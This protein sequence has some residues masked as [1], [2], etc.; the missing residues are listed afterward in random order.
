MIKNKEVIKL[1]LLDGIIYCK[2]LKLNHIKIPT[3]NNII[4]IIIKSGISFSHPI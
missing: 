3:T 1:T 4:A 2:P